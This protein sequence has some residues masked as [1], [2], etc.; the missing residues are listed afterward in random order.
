MKSL[1]VLI[2]A[3]SVFSATAVASLPF[4]DDFEN[5]MGN[6]TKVPGAA[7]ALQL[8]GPDPWKSIDPGP[9]GEHE[10]Y[11]ARQHAYVGGGNGYASFH[12][13]G[14]QTGSIKAEVYLFE[15]LTTSA[16]PVQAAMTLTPV[17]I[18]GD[19][20]FDDFLRIGILQ[21]AGTNAFYSFRTAA[22]G[23]VTTSVARKN[24]WTK[25]GIEVDPGIGSEVRFYIDDALVGTSSRVT[26][27]LSAITL[28]QNFS[29]NENFWYDG[30]NV[31]PEPASALL[32]LIG[33][34]LLRRRS[35]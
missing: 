22:D 14:E 34:P 33:L 4:H 17:D 2:V 32:L 28:G 7:E 35:R 13:F 15:D 6:W 19:P 27:N 8:A 3:V 20:S 31:V 9:L 12:N 24:G 11:S 10:G 30:V 25:L 26:D 16:D 21:Y 23:F 29:N 1:L 5:G 18:G